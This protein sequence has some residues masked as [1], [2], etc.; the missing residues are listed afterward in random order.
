MAPALIVKEL[1]STGDCVNDVVVPLLIAAVVAVVRSLVAIGSILSRDC[2]GSVRYN[3]LITLAGVV[4]AV[5]VEETGP[6]QPMEV[7]VI[8]DLPIHVIK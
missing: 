5:C 2:A 8:M 7:A 1:Q 4:V 6:L 3:C